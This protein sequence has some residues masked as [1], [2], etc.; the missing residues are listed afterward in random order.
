MFMLPGASPVSFGP[1]SARKYSSVPVLLDDA[2]LLHVAHHADDGEP[3][4]LAAEPGFTRRPI[5]L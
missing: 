3:G 1:W 5:E 2:A 4:T